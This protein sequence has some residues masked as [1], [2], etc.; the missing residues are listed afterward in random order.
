MVRLKKRG[1]GSTV[2]SYLSKGQEWL[3]GTDV[4]EL[5]VLI[6]LEREGREHMRRAQTVTAWQSRGCSFLYVE[7]GG[8]YMSVQ[9][10]KFLPCVALKI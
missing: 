7:L 3:T 6:N 2:S 10:F 4:T 1:K 9:I 8:S 5:R